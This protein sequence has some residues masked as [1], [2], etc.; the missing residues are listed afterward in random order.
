MLNHLV[1]QVDEELFPDDASPQVQTSAHISPER[2]MPVGHG[3]LRLGTATPSTVPPSKVSYAGPSATPTVTHYPLATAA[4]PREVDYQDV[5]SGNLPVG[6]PRH[7]DAVG[8]GADEVTPSFTTE[9][10]SKP[11]ILGLMLPSVRRRPR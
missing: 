4:T 10:V 7:E 11:C 8:I 1:P 5:L 3:T 6:V 2:S 9:L